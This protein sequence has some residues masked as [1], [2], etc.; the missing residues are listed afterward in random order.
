[1]VCSLY[2]RQQWKLQC[3]KATCSVQK[4][5][6]WGI[7]KTHITG[8]EGLVNFADRVILQK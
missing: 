7:L 5:G 8:I 1:M 2:Y 4:A 3:G 6:I